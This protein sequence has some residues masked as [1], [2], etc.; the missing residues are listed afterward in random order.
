MP[1]NTIQ[2]PSDLVYTEEVQTFTTWKNNNDQK[3]IFKLV[4]DKTLAGSHPKFG[5]DCKAVHFLLVEIE[6]GKSKRIPTE[7]D[8]AIRT[9][10]P[11]TGQ[12][13]G[14][15]CPWLTKVGEEDIVV[16]KSLDYKAAWQE[17]EV[18]EVAQA[19]K[20]EQDLRDALA[21]IEKRKAGK[22]K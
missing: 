4:T 20:K 8:Q 2:D 22:K 14:G 1:Q 16:H 6:P 12:V 9:V 17:Q 18:Q 15:L 5:A 11:K 3:A 10:N 13:V 19:M 21:E 7:Y